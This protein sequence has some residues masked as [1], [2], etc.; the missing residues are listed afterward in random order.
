VSRPGEIMPNPGPCAFQFIAMSKEEAEVELDKLTA[1][2]L[3]R[4]K[5]E[6]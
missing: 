5:K 3:K 1:R 6:H 2:I 4:A